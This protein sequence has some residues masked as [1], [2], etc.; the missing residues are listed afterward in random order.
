MQEVEVS[1]KVE[2]RL[3]GSIVYLSQAEV[4][5][6]VGACYATVDSH[7]ALGLLPKPVKRGGKVKDYPEHEIDTIVAARGVGATN[8][9]IREI[10]IS[11]FKV[12]KQL[13]ESLVSQHVAAA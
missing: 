9:E 5:D 8:D 13:F 6:R 11:L 12:R 2:Q 10:V 1:E 3:P 4:C 7:V